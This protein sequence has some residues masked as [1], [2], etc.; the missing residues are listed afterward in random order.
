MAWRTLSALQDGTTS[1]VSPEI[2]TNVV[3]VDAV[4]A[5]S[6]EFEQR[7]RGV[8]GQGEYRRFDAECASPLG[9]PV[10]DLLS[11]PDAWIV[12]VSCRRKFRIAATFRV[13]GS[14][15]SKF[16]AASIVREDCLVPLLF[17]AVSYWCLNGFGFEQNGVDGCADG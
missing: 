12:G 15:R 1:P 4:G 2:L 14:M 10:D 11:N 7:R 8:G 5:V 6:V 16:R 17:D 13:R 9:D 3:P